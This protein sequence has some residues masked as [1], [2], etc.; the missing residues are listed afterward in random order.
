MF[1]RFLPRAIAG[2]LLLGLLVFSVGCGGLDYKARGT[3]K[4]KVTIG[5]KHL[6]IGTVA[7]YSTK[8]EGYTGT[9]SI[10][11]NGNYVMTD[12]P[13]GE[14]KITVSVPSLPPG[15][16]A[17]MKFGPTPKDQKDKGGSV[18]PND[19]RRK[20]TIMGDLPEHVVPIP[21]KY[22][23][24][25]SSGLTYTVQRGEQTHNIELQP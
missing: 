7:F 19:P 2:S 1:S 9:A 25:D 13:L 18:D 3:V 21:G 22:S 12:A 24:T 11:K 15:G 16:L 4:G 6:T 17:R 14:V 20:I 8:D 5:P 23:T 10:D